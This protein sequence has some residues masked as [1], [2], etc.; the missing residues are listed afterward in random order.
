MK[1][2]R[3]HSCLWCGI[4]SAAARSAFCA[5]DIKRGGV[6]LVDQRHRT[7]LFQWTKLVEGFNGI[8]IME[9]FS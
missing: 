8:S 2:K 1:V 4:R 5:V 6:K 3:I 7:H 9:I